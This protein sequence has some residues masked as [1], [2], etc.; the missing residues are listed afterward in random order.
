MFHHFSHHGRSITLPATVLTEDNWE[1][2]RE[3]FPTWADDYV[4]RYYTSGN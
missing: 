1:F 2:I 4:H 3:V